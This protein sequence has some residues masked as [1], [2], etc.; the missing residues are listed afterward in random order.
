MK[1]ENDGSPRCLEDLPSVGKRIA[2]DLRKIGIRVPADL[3]RREPL[4]VYRGLEA[5][6]Q[7]RH[8]P[9]MLYTLLAVE[10]FLGS[11]EVVPW[12]SFTKAGKEILKREGVSAVEFRRR[13]IPWGEGGGW[14]GM[15]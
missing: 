4:E 3:Q 14:G 2:A 13:E 8:D 1:A 15:V 12:W 7:E 11:G 10:H 5:V 9:C 6:M